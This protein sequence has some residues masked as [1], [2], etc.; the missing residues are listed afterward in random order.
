MHRM[1]SIPTLLRPAVSLA[2]AAPAPVAP[3]QLSVPVP[4]LP[5]IEPPVPPSLV[6]PGRPPR[7]PLDRRLPPELRGREGFPLLMRRLRL[8]VSVAGTSS[9]FA[10]TRATHAALRAR[11]L[12]AVAKVA[13]PPPASRSTVLQRELRRRTFD[14]GLVADVKRAYPTEAVVAAS[15][16]SG[17]PLR[18][19]NRMVQAT[20]VLV[21]GVARDPFD[22]SLRPD[23]ALG[24]A[25]AV[26]R[27]VPPGGV[28]VTGE[29]DA[30]LR[31]VMRQQAEQV[32]ATFVNA[33]PRDAHAMPGLEVPTVLDAF[34]RSAL[35]VG[36]SAAERV[37]AMARLQRRLSWQPSALPGLRCFDGSGLP[38]PPSLRAALDHLGHVGPARAH[39][40]VYVHGDRRH[41]SAWL[42]PVLRQA[43]E[44]GALAH[45]CLIGAGATALAEELRHLPST[46][47]LDRRATVDSV[48]RTLGREGPGAAVVTLGDT[49]GPWPKAFAARLWRADAPPGQWVPPSAAGVAWKEDPGPIPQAP[50]LRAPSMGVRPVVNILGDLD[51]ELAQPDVRP[52]PLPRPSPAPAPALLQ[53]IPA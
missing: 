20:H 48:V 32:G 43:L 11:R 36:L 13:A 5:S 9:T 16:D 34:L 26:A 35:G 52:K 30:S 15:G 47:F 14:E 17:R 49:V 37:Q 31:K 24:R 22:G 2:S 46:L 4:A 40:V 21:P 18:N 38:N 25:V 19:F 10:L 3:G 28:L 44:D 8:R 51:R 29:R 12:R 1:K 50:M 41:E 27:S 42:G 39:A 23:L 7:D 6:E 53:P 33:A 45:A